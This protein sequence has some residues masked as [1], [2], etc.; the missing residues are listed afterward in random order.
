MSGTTAP[1]NSIVFT[2]RVSKGTTGANNVPWAFTAYLDPPAEL[3][4][5]NATFA[6]QIVLKNP[7]Q[8]IAGQNDSF[9][10]KLL[11]WW[12]SDPLFLTPQVQNTYEE[13]PTQPASFGALLAVPSSYQDGGQSWYPWNPEL[14]GFNLPSWEPGDRCKCAAYVDGVMLGKGIKDIEAF[15]AGTQWPFGY[16]N[17]VDWELVTYKAMS[18]GQVAPSSGTGNDQCCALES[19]VWPYAPLPQFNISKG[20][21]SLTQSFWNMNRTNGL[22]PFIKGNALRPTPGINWNNAFAIDASDVYTTQITGALEGGYFEPFAPPID[23]NCSNDPINTGFVAMSWNDPGVFSPRIGGFSMAVSTQANGESSQNNWNM[24]MTGM[25]KFST[26]QR[27]L[28]SQFSYIRN[29]LFLVDINEDGTDVDGTGET[30][31]NPRVFLCGNGRTS[32]YNYIQNRNAVF[33]AADGT[34]STPTTPNDMAYAGIFIVPFAPLYYS[35]INYSTPN[36]PNIFQPKPFGQDDFNFQPWVPGCSVPV[37]FTEMGAPICCPATLDNNSGQPGYPEINPG[38]NLLN[39][40]MYPG[41]QGNIQNNGGANTFCSFSVQYSQHIGDDPGHYYSQLPWILNPG[42]HMPVTGYMIDWM[43]YGCIYSGAAIHRSGVYP[44][45]ELQA[46][47][48]YGHFL[49]AT[50]SAISGLVPSAP[51]GNPDQAGGFR[52]KM[53]YAYTNRPLFMMQDAMADDGAGNKV[54]TGNFTEPVYITSKITIPPGYYTPLEL[55]NLITQGLNGKDN[56]T[57]ETP[58]LRHYN[59]NDP[60]F[61]VIFTGTGF[62]DNDKGAFN[63]NTVGHP[64]PWP[65]ILPKTRAVQACAGPMGILTGGCPSLG[66]E[67][68]SQGLL[69]LSGSAAPYA[70]LPYAWSTIATE[71]AAVFSGQGACTHTPWSYFLNGDPADPLYSLATTTPCLGIYQQSAPNSSAQGYQGCGSLGQH[72]FLPG[73]LSSQAWIDGYG[74]YCP[75]PD[76]P[77]LGPYGAAIVSLCDGGAIERAFWETMGF[78]ASNLIEIWAPKLHYYQVFEGYTFSKSLQQWVFSQ[79]NFIISNQTTRSLYLPYRTVTADGN[80]TNNEL[81]LDSQLNPANVNIV[82]LSRTFP[83]APYNEGYFCNTQAVDAWCSNT[84]RTS[85]ASLRPNFS[86]SRIPKA[87]PY[88]QAAR[89]QIRVPPALDT[90]ASMYSTRFYSATADNPIYFFF[91]QNPGNAA[92]PPTLAT[93]SAAAYVANGGTAYVIDS[94][95][96]AYGYQ[97]PA[98]TNFSH[99][100]FGS[101]Y[102][103]NSVYSTCGDGDNTGET[104]ASPEENIV[105]S[106]LTPIVPTATYAQLAGRVICDQISNVYVNVDPLITDR[107]VQGLP[108]WSD[109]WN[110]PPATAPLSYFADYCNKAPSNV[111]AVITNNRIQAPWNLTYQFVTADSVTPGTVWNLSSNYSDWSSLLITPNVNTP[112]KTTN[113]D[114]SEM[115]AQSPASS[116]LVAQNGVTPIYYDLLNVRL[117]SNTFSSGIIHYCQGLRHSG[118]IPCPIGNPSAGAI[119]SI[120]ITSPFFWNTPAT[121]M[122]WYRVEVFSANMVPAEHITDISFQMSLTPTGELT[123]DAQAFLQG[124]QMSQVTKNKQTAIVSGNQMF[125]T[126]PAQDNSGGGGLNRAQ[127]M[128]GFGGGNGGGSSSDSESDDGSGGSGRQGSKRIKKSASVASTPQ[129]LLGGTNANVPNAVVEP[130]IIAGTLQ[131]ERKPINNLRGSGGNAALFGSRK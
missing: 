70:A 7:T 41:L 56:L 108:L 75:Y 21:Q 117:T 89:Y 124:A 31:A 68:N 83:Y 65:K 97:V 44:N 119:N 48:I 17:T 34:V 4:V 88:Y 50:L 129:H 1:N 99:T 120:S 69:Q 60:N 39:R 49:P 33:V 43:V 92:N 11:P 128:P 131:K 130:R 45:G 22:V 115:V 27:P 32:A 24:P 37:C 105:T 71:Q 18:P 62:E 12:N 9:T 54:F 36:N 42:Y 76:S 91:P 10:I 20:V 80:W 57:S 47:S 61:S 77:V 29:Q 8:I 2:Q 113:V 51:D 25:M 30:A 112:D 85:W 53:R 38:F 114:P 16:T 6:A 58:V 94:F 84:T 66:M 55:A 52:G 78:T 19:D 107:G 72:G 63:D 73:S 106:A 14:I 3:P 26:P 74:Y 125:P 121:T 123:L 86:Y 101:W 87:V 95:L 126:T 122:A 109:T 5:C 98:I 64:N 79:E 116:V 28:S 103:A 67:L 110:G 15:G 127:R 102:C 59:L 93:Q 81:L 23:I 82:S 40:G 118:T 46:A 111:F 35:A 100:G 104:F 96:N 90:T 13:F